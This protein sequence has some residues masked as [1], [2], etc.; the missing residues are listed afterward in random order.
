[1]QNLALNISMLS[2]SLIIRLTLHVLTSPPHLGVY[3]FCVLNDKNCTL[4]LNECQLI[5]NLVKYQ[6]LKVL[7]F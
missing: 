4:R 5:H 3:E 7:N 1:M 2:F 6:N